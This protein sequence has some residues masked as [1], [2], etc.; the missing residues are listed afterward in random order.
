MSTVSRAG[1]WNPR[2]SKWKRAAR[3]MLEWIRIVVEWIIGR[4][5]HLN[6]ALVNSSYNT[7][8]GAQVTCWNSQWEWVAGMRS[9]SFSSS[10]SWCP[11]YLQNPNLGCC[12]RSWGSHG[13]RLLWS[14]LQFFVPKHFWPFSQKS[15]LTVALCALLIDPIIEKCLQSRD[16]PSFD[17]LRSDPL[18]IC[19]IVPFNRHQYQSLCSDVQQDKAMKWCCLRFNPYVYCWLQGKKMSTI[20]IILNVDQL[21]MCVSVRLWR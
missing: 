11:S 21:G 19:S 20:A 1:E 5:V 18:G 15:F 4:R 13:S 9:F 10:F 17:Q 12:P 6:A 14:C 7:R 3:L 2:V 16:Q 8:S